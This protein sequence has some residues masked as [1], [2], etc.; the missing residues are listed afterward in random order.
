MFILACLIEKYII[1]DKTML[2]QPRNEPFV[3]CLVAHV[4]GHNQYDS[5]S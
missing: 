5:L 1:E 2:V 4:Q 3:G